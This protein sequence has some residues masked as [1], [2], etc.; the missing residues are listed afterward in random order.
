MYAVRPDR[1]ATV[2]GLFCCN[3]T[4]ASHAF[5]QTTG[6]C[7]TLHSVHGS[8]KCVCVVGLAREGHRTIWL[9]REQEQCVA[10]DSLKIVNIEH[11]KTEQCTTVKYSSTTL[12]VL[13]YRYAWYHKEYCCSTAFE[14]R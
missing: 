1:L 11:V 13:L 12:I 2:S 7:A 9:G 14:D 6:R 3:P 10:F 5:F 4:P 8:A